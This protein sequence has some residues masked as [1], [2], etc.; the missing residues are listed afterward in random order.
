MTR[1]LS[2]LA[3][4]TAL[5]ALSACTTPRDAPVGNPATPAV[6]ER[7]DATR[8]QS[9]VGQAGTPELLERA[10]TAAGASTARMLKPDQMVTLEYLE[11]RL[12][13]RVDESNVVA[14]VDCG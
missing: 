4:T 13:L 14:S 2:A 5:L 6:T 1:P 10:R 7:C 9:F 11:G 12:N 8:A 3:C